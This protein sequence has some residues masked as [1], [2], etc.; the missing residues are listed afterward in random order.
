MSDLTILS[1][2]LP[3]DTIAGLEDRAA[4][5]TASAMA[6][7]TIRAYAADWRD[8]E[9]WC[10][11]RGFAALPAEESTVVLYLTD[12]AGRAK[13]A[14]IS[15]RVVAIRHAHSAAGLVSPVDG[16]RVRVLVRGIRRELG[17]AGRKKR[18]LSTADVA[19]MVATCGDDATGLRDRAVLLLGFAGAFRRSEIAALRVEDIED[20]P[21]GVAVT[22]RRG[23]T[24]QEGGG[25]VVGIPFGRNPATCPAR[26]VRTWLAH[27]A[28]TE[29]A[30]Q[31]PAGGIFDLCDRTVAEI[32][33]RRAKLAGIDG[34]VSGHSM[35]AG[36][37]T[38]ASANGADEESTMRQAR[39]ASVAV[40]R[41][42]I[43]H[44]TLFV[45]NSAAT[46]GL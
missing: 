37:I 25:R 33:K 14:T 35:R 1:P 22:I 34:D 6:S 12:L 42:Y 41:E 40:H 20:R 9:S 28:G 24:D 23:K 2:A 17:T 4:A 31:Q 43:R 7:N 45:K 26:A 39:H 10:A 11:A 5:F 13:V 3:A 16:S 15:R 18:A 8:F 36:H 46:L 30:D 19:A 38:Q 27:R 21:E 29:P 32:V 44:G